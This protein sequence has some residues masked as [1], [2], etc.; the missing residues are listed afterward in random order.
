[1]RVFDCIEVEEACV[2]NALFE[3]GLVAIA[4]IVGE[5]PRGAE[6]DDAGC[7]GELAMDVLLQDGIQFFGRD[8][9]GV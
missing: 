5:E 1:V 4:A 7:R 8:E 2:R 3:E 9:V 6:R